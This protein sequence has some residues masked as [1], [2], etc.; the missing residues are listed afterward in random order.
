MQAGLCTNGIVVLGGSYAVRRADQRPAVSTE[1]HRDPGGQ[2][3]DLAK[4]HQGGYAQRDALV[5]EN[6]RLAKSAACLD[7]S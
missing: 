7:G 2:S 1:G 5:I 4:G 3:N 6:P